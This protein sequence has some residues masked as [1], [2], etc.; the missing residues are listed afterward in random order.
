MK[1]YKFKFGLKVNPQDQRT[2]VNDNRAPFNCSCYKITNHDQKRLKKVI[3]DF[4][5]LYPP[6]TSI[7]CLLTNLRS[8]EGVFELPERCQFKFW[9]CVS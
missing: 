1:I 6:T 7:T 9:P 8:S 3:H 5:Q 4:D 2:L